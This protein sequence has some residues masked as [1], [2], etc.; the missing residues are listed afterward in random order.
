MSRLAR[1]FAPIQRRPGLALAIFWPVAFIGTHF[2]RFGPL[3]GEPRRYPVDKLAH[4]LCYA[5]L[6]WLMTR[7]LA[8]RMRPAAAIVLTLLLVAA[9]GA[10]DE[11]TQP[12]V[13]RTTDLWDFIADLAGAVLGVLF[14]F[15]W[16]SVLPGNSSAGE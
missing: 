5:V 6:A 15:L 11:L 12:F 4:F 9:Y 7:L 13:G 16:Q 1:I 14:A 3:R 8:Q 2:P 10:I